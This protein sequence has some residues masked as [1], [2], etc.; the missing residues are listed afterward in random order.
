MPEELQ[1]NASLGAN[2]DPFNNSLWGMMITGH[3]PV[4]LQVF[5]CTTE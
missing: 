1:R 4:V 5:V 3:G 2:F